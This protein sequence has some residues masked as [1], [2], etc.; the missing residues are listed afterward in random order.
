M[1]LSPFLSRSLALLLLLAVL[2]AGWTLV[3]EP[4]I[5]ARSAQ[6][7]TIARS[8]DLI[9]R[10]DRVG[11]HRDRLEKSLAGMRNRGRSTAGYL[12]GANHSL[13]AAALQDRI[14]R[15]VTVN[16]GAI[17]SSQALPPKDDQGL[18]RLPIR[19]QLSADI[20]ALQKIL[21]QFEVGEPG[22]A[23]LFLN[24]VNIRSQRARHVRRTRRRGS[25][26]VASNPTGNRALTVSFEL[27]GYYRPE[28]SQ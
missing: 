5:K 1:T 18:K 20:I 3:V 25:K 12:I 22:G 21:H 15:I 8:H 11:M 23:Y 10:Y 28:K 13:T 19:V 2:A 24:D 9:A 4:V 14:K 6:R 26:N 17:R 16:G 7:Q 27:Y